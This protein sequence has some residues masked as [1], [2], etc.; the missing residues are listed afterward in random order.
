[1][2]FSPSLSSQARLFIRPLLSLASQVSVALWLK[3]SIA[4]R[5]LIAER[6][7]RK[8][9]FIEQPGGFW[10]YVEKDGVLQLHAVMHVAN[11]NSE[12]TIISRPPAMLAD[13]WT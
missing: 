8:L 9:V 11:K 4:L 7:R 5:R 10:D 3:Y 12:A 6:V 13:C 2:G 1:V